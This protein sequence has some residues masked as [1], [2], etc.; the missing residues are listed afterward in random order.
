MMLLIPPA[1]G[2]PYQTQRTQLTGVDYE[3]SWAFNAR[4]GSWAISFA[5]IGETED[6]TPVLDGAKLHIGHDLLGRCQHPSRPAGS[7]WVYSVDGSQEQPGLDDLGSRC[8]VLY[9]EP[10][11][12]LP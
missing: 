1:S 9:L 10:G 11:E 12:V 2:V 5:V 3:V 6:P 4:S 7:V 8:H